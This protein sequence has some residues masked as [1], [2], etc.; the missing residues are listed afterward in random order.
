MGINEKH[1]QA[2]GTGVIKGGAGGASLRESGIVRS[3]LSLDHRQHLPWK[4]RSR[5]SNS[6]L[7][8]TAA[9]TYP[10][11][12]G[13][14][15]RARGTGTTPRTRLLVSR[16]R[17]ESAPLLIIHG[18]DGTA[19]GMARSA[20]RRAGLSARD[21]IS[22]AAKVRLGNDVFARTLT[23]PTRRASLQRCPAKSPSLPSSP[24]VSSPGRSSFL[25][26]GRI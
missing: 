1:L 12:L 21:E 4:A 3:P 7:T 23:P 20:S 19:P 9:S 22:D 24:F 2:A 15:A 8:R 17:F 10:G 18:Q 11:T 6:P 14:R 26:F 13:G 25:I 16:E 5:T